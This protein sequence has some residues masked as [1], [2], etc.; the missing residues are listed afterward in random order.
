MK[1][2]VSPGACSFAAHVLVY[3]RDL[4]IEV[5]P[6]SLADPSSAVKQIN[7]VGRVPVL[8][9]DDASIITEN[10]ALLPFL[11]DLRP[12]TELFAA[13]GTVERARI[14]SW[15]GYLSAEIH[16]GS[17]RVINRPERFSAD[18]SHYPAIRLAGRALLEKALAPIEQQLLEQ[19]LKGRK[20]LVG[21][22][23]SIADVYLGVFAGWLQ[24]FGEPFSTLPHLRELHER[25]EQRPAVI[26]ARAAE[27]AFS[28]VLQSA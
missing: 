20:V 7:P 28:A 26:Q 19:Q 11:A 16:A 13:A 1:L 25:F 23:F 18:T 15:I 6:V 8:Q 12:G 4:P 9:L 5:I 27:Q 17:F 22:H 10:S 24:R 14:Q 21:E 3:E 2:F